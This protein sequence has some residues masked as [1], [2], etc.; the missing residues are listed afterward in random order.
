M[1]LAPHGGISSWMVLAPHGGI[2]SWMVHACR[3]NYDIHRYHVAR[4][5]RMVQILVLFSPAH[6]DIEKIR[7]MKFADI[8]K[9]RTV[10]L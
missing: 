6:V 1:V 9:I 10:T 4:N 3:S 7:T 2:S 5:L 8:A